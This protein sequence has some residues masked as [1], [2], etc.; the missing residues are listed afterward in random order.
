M[1]TDYFIEMGGWDSSFEGSALASTDFAIRCY[2]DGA[3]VKFLSKELTHFDHE[4]ALGGTHAPI[5]YAFVEWDHLLYKKIH[6]D[7]AN[8]SR[9][10]IDFNNW[11]NAPS[12]WERRFGDIK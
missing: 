8:L 2:R 4:G 9:I 1:Y 3:T 11:K 12:I 6:N 10:K 5:Y 7:P